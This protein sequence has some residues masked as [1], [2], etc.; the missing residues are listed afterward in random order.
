MIPKTTSGGW[1]DGFASPAYQ[2]GSR[3]VQTLDRPA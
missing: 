1:N 2:P 3:A